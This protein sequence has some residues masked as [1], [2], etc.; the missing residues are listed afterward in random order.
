MLLSALATIGAFEAQTE[1]S[2]LD[3][4]DTSIEDGGTYTV[5]L[6]E[7]SETPLVFTVRNDELASLSLTNP[8]SL[9]G[10][11]IFT[12]VSDSFAD[13]SLTSGETTT[14][15]IAVDTST[16]GTFSADIRFGNNDPNENPFD[17]TL[18][19]TIG[20]G[21]VNVLPEEDLSTGINSNL[22]HSGTV[23]L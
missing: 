3:P 22:G 1:I 5:I 4:T 18:E 8:I 20:S 13:T 21:P 17:I 9:T 15:E 14:F 2:V 16:L 10:D 23:R 19:V 6:A 11:S 12:L 7:N